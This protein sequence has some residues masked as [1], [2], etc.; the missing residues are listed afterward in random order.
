MPGLCP[1]SWGRDG[2]GSVM[3]SI[4][5]PCLVFRIAPAGSRSLS[6]SWE[7]PNRYIPLTFPSTDQHFHS[8]VHVFACEEKMP[9]EFF[10]SFLPFLPSSAEEDPSTTTTTSF[11]LFL[12]FFFLRID[13]DESIYGWKFWSRGFSCSMPRKRQS[14][15]SSCCSAAEEGERGKPGEQ[16]ES[17][18]RRK[19]PAALYT[20]PRLMILVVYS[21]P[22]PRPDGDQS[23]SPDQISRINHISWPPFSPLKTNPFF[24][25]FFSFLFLFSNLLT[26]NWVRFFCVTR[27][28]G[29]MEREDIDYC[30]PCSLFILLICS[31]QSH[32]VCRS[33]ARRTTKQPTSTNR[34]ISNFV[35]LFFFFFFSFPS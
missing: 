10:P 7:Q 18:I 34:S 14:Q 1:L 5:A 16:K 31:C 9:F 23:Q 19:T 12:F 30:M 2:T 6:L 13:S 17:D 22:T 35:S 25:S 11:L 21:S 32:P 3:Q 8:I 24:F 20:L 4:C 26:T 28:D 15:S 33:T 29:G 27:R